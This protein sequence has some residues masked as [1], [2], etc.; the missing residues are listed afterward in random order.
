MQAATKTGNR[1]ESSFW[2]HDRS[3]SEATWGCRQ[4]VHESDH[5]A[6]AGSR[7]RSGDDSIRTLWGGRYVRCEAW[8][9]TT[10]SAGL[11]QRMNPGDVG[12]HGR[13]APEVATLAI[14]VVCTRAIA[15]VVGGRCDLAAGL[16]L[17]L[18]MAEVLLRR[19]TGLM[20][21]V[22]RRRAPDQLER[23][24][25]QQERE[26]PTTHVSDSRLTILVAARKT[27]GASLGSLRFPPTKATKA[28]PS[29]R[30]AGPS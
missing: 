12:L 28:T 8:F 16:V 11:G 29:R 26:Y 25:K 3:D 15:R 22:R 30:A 27:C 4:S 9:S 10:R 24:N 13:G 21:A 18:V 23:H 19:D 14:G 7:G 1:I 17:V 20:R 5:H 2:S 6:A